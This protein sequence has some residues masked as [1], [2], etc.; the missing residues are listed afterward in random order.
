MSSRPGRSILSPSPCAS[1]CRSRCCERKG[2]CRR[3]SPRAIHGTRSRCPGRSRGVGTDGEDQAAQV[4]AKP[5]DD[6]AA[7]ARALALLEATHVFP[8]EYDL[9]VIA[10]NREPTTLAVK[11]AVAGDGADVPHRIV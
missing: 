10:F 3:R 2:P 8:C 4:E 11:G 5:T 6:P 7:R 9:T 1:S